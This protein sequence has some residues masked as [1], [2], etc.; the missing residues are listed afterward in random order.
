MCDFLAKGLKGFLGCCC[1][2]YTKC[3]CGLEEENK[4]GKNRNLKLMAVAAGEETKMIKKRHKH[5]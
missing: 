4:I 1:C 2:C 5:N 3:C